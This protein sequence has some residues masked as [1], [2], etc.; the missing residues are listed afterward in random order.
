MSPT[1]GM[2]V[3]WVFGRAP[4]DVDHCATCVSSLTD[5]GKRHVVLYDVRYEYIC[6]MY[7]AFQSLQCMLLCNHLTGLEQRMTHR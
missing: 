1:R 6:G 5:A 7:V 3:L 2:P 4:A